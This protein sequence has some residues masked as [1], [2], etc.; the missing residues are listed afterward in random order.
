[1]ENYSIDKVVKRK[2]IHVY[3]YMK[4]IFYV[5]I[6]GYIIY[7]LFGLTPSVVLC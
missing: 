5:T 1:M 7:L 2:N 3:I 4:H 6:Y